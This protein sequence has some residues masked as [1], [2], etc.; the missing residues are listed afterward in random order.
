M[1]PYNAKIRR[2]RVSRGSP[3][4]TVNRPPVHDAALIEGP[5][6][7]IEEIVARAQEAMAEAS[8]IVLN[9]FRPRS[10]AVIV[11]WRAPYMDGRGREFWARVLPMLATKAELNRR[12][13]PIPAT[14]DQDTGQLRGHVDW[15]S[16]C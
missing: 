13:R 6:D 9:G 1:R 10:D 4:A 7:T 3:P 15:A 12:R 5:S 11:R 8:A 2:K 16:A 14:F